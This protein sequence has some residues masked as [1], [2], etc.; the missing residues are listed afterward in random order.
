MRA[1]FAVTCLLVSSSACTGAIGEDPD[2]PGLVDV[3]EGAAGSTGGTGPTGTDPVI[4]PPSSCSATGPSK[5]PAVRRLSRPEYRNVMADLFPGVVLPALDVPEDSGRGGFENVAEL[6]A[7]TPLHIE[8]YEAI[9]YAV[10]A[11]VSGT[12]AAARTLAGCAPTNAAEQ[13]ACGRKFI[14][15]FGLRAFRRPLSP[16]EISDY[17]A[18]FEASRAAVDF[19]GAIQLVVSRF[20]QSVDFLYRIESGP[21]PDDWMMAGRLSFL[22]WQ[23]LPDA[24]LLEAARLGRLTSRD[25]IAT[26]AQRMLR[27]PRGRRA[28]VDFHRQWLDF[29]KLASE[30]DKDTTLY[31]A[32]TPTLMKAVRDESDRFVGSAIYEKNGGLAKLLTSP[33]TLVNAELARLY[34]VAAP[35]GS[36]WAPTTL[37]ARQRAGVLTRANFLASQGHS[38]NG[39]PP[40]R[41]IAILNRFLCTTVPDPPDDADTSNPG[42]AADAKTKT[43]RQL[44]EERAASSQCAGC[45]ALFNPLGYALENFDA[46]G[47][48]RATDNGKPVNASVTLAVADLEG[49]LTGPIELSNRLAGSAQVAGCM[50]TKWFT[51]AAGRDVG[52]N[53]ACAVGEL[54]K[55]VSSGK[56]ILDLV[57]QT[58]VTPQ[59]LN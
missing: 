33:E 34:G 7:P 19:G 11:K 39:S 14:E 38:E 16:V 56:G 42:E 30:S 3:E 23:S 57:M 5:L 9:A 31:K 27:D 45:H 51:F 28:V 8:R 10:S 59:F 58:V 25:G 44:F 35:A 43:N 41:G 20:L 53:D 24:A 48:Y 55:T 29:D 12:E 2:D 46:I 50:A 22:I 49:A 21:R 47:R 13:Q 1:F 32:W 52:P 17:V 54:T 40:L 37:P 36:A 18:S 4:P 26:E 15:S 6:L